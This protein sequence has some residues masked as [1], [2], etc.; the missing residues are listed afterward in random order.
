M[1]KMSSDIAAVADLISVAVLRRHPR[2]WIG[3]I[4]NTIFFR[5]S[6]ILH[7]HFWMP[8]YQAE[9]IGVPPSRRREEQGLLGDVARWDS[10]T[11]ENAEG[12]E[13]SEIKA[14]D[15]RVDI[16]AHASGIEAVQVTHVL[17]GI[18][19]SSEGKYP[20]KSERG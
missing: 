10:S 9:R 18:V 6:E 17:S 7:L 19:V 13:R 2:P 14:Q 11:A 1:P 4:L 8:L 20:E 5:E 16:Y 12:A 15:L 3:S